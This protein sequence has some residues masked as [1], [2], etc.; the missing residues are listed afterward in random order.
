MR[1]KAR[2]VVTN[3]AKKKIRELIARTPGVRYQSVGNAVHRQGTA[4]LLA[5]RCDICNEA[6]FGANG[7]GVVQWLC[8]ASHKERVAA[9]FFNHKGPCDNVIQV[10]AER[11]ELG[12]FWEEASTLVS[13]DAQDH[14]DAVLELYEWSREHERRL[15][16]LFEDVAIAM[17]HGW[18]VPRTSSWAAKWP[19]PLTAGEVGRRLADAFAEDSPAFDR[20]ASA[21][22]S[23]CVPTLAGYFA[24]LLQTGAQR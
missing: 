9:L 11:L 10:V 12:P 7:D 4:A 23:A 19:R 15:G 8:G 14:R 24:L 13:Q 22:N 18:R 17:K 1:R 21:A 3:K 6:L 5:L 2:N 20:A 16:R